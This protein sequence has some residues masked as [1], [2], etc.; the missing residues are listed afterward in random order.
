MQVLASLAFVASKSKLLNPSLN[1]ITVALS[2]RFLTSPRPFAVHD[3]LFTQSTTQF[4]RSNPTDLHLRLF[5]FVLNSHWN[6][7]TDSCC[8]LMPELCG[9][10]QKRVVMVCVFFWFCV[11]S[12]SCK[13]LKLFRVNT[14]AISWSTVLLHACWLEL[15]PLE[16]SIPPGLLHYLPFGG[17]GG[18][19]LLPLVVT[20]KTCYSHVEVSIIRSSQEGHVLKE[21]EACD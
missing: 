11:R 20:C 12:L 1:F 16:G 7:N 18:F 6:I 19:V 4:K 21:N 10:E 8:Q 17:F 15:L 14:A 5:S 3:L 9:R 13:Q 2:G